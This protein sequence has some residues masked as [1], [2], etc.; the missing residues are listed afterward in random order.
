MIMP[1]FVKLSDWA[2][3]H[4]DEEF[5][6]FPYIMPSEPAAKSPAIIFEMPRPEL[7]SGIGLTY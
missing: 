5:A 1:M 2:F 7:E 4:A 3:V 6:V